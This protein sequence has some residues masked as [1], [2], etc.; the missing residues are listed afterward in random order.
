MFERRRIES[1]QIEAL[2]TSQAALL[3]ELHKLKKE[4]EQLKAMLSEE[5]CVGE[6]CRACENYYRDM[7]GGVCVKN[8]KCKNFT[9]RFGSPGR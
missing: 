4:N 3:S 7:H 1:Q 5:R 6:H 9:R 8:I 2:E